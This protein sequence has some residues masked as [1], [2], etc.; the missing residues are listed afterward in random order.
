M[1][2]RR[3]PPKSA[4]AGFWFPSEVVTD[5]TSTHPRVLGELVPAAG[6]SIVAAG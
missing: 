6:L 2:R 5:K 1:P 3:L 4:F